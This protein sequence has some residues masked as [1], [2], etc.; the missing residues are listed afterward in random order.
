MPVF[1]CFLGQPFVRS[2]FPEFSRMYS[3]DRNEICRIYLRLLHRRITARHTWHQQAHAA[4][5]TTVWRE[6]QINSSLW[7]LVVFKW[8]CCYQNHIRWAWQQSQAP[9]QHQSP[10]SSWKMFD[11]LH[12]T[13]IWVLTMAER[14]RPNFW[15][16]VMNTTGLLSLI[17]EFIMFCNHNHINH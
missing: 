4:I 15:S 14:H 8:V 11:T 10:F 1:V 3:T 5:H 16:R 12:S 9:W 2:Q 17:W 7:P 13:H 6:H